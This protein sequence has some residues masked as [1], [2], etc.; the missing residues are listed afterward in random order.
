MCLS[1]LIHWIYYSLYSTKHWRL[2]LIRGLGRATVTAHVRIQRRGARGPDPHGQLQ[3]YRVLK[4]YWPGSPGKSQ[5]YIASIQCSAIFGPPA[6]RHLNG[7]SLA[8]R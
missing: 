1:I 8:G 2:S 7:V 3:S 5:S 4:Q 6:K